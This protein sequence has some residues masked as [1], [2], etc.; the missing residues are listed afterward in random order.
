MITI[1]LQRAAG[2]PVE[3]D[4]GWI[5][6]SLKLLVTGDGLPVVFEALIMMR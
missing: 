3:V 2:C 5:T 6:R 1:W 4:H